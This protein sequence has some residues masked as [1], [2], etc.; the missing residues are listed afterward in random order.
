MRKLIVTEFVSL[1]G[2]MEEPGNW[3]L[4]FWNDEIAR[5]KGDEFSAGDAQLLGRVTY[6]GFA[7]AWPQSQDEGAE[8]FNRMPKY[9]VTRTLKELAWNNSHPIAGDIAA[10]VR[11]LK[12]QPGKDILVSGSGMLVDTLLSAGLVDE[13]HLLVYPLL[14][15]KGKRLFSNGVHSALRLASS[16]AFTGGV[17]ALIYVP[18]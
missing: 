6:E 17:L 15:G 18:A 1:D 3:S 2:V 7:K 9:V 5:F 12:Q 16:R 8:Q 14:L 13:L 4:P 10:A 11:D